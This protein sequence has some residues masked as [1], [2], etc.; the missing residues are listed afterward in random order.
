MT[1]CDKA[2]LDIAYTLHLCNINCRAEKSMDS[3]IN[4]ALYVHMSIHLFIFPS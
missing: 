4:D 3:I 2:V 1:F